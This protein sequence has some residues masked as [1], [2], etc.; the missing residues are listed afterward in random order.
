MGAKWFPIVHSVCPL[1]HPDHVIPPGFIQE[2]PHSGATSEGISLLAVHLESPDCVNERVLAR[3]REH[4]LAHAEGPARHSRWQAPVALAPAPKARAFGPCEGLGLF[5]TCQACR[6][7]PG[8][9][10]LLSPRAVPT[11]AIHHGS[12]GGSPGNQLH[13]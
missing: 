5:A 1:P 2:L 9:R 11:A 8:R 13:G 3:A 4:A 6:S 10:V 7:L 12:L